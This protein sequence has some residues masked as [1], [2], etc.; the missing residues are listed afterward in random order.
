MENS[1][2]FNLKILFF[3]NLMDYAE[4]I[5]RAKAP[6]EKTRIYDAADI[7]LSQIAEELETARDNISRYKI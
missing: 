6:D 1:S 4:R 3:H 2:Q 7:R 5:E